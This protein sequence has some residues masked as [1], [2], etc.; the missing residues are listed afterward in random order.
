MQIAAGKFK[1]ECLRLMDTVNQNK[2]DIV[3]TK[4]GKPVAKL[5]PFQNDE[6]PL[7]FGYLKGTVTEQGDIV[8]AIDEVWEA[9]E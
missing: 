9:D 2:E 6:H 5:V 3:I 4:Y 8:S 1:A 7:L